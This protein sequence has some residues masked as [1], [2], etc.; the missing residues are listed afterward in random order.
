MIF[1][2]QMFDVLTNQNA[3]NKRIDLECHVINIYVCKV[4]S[5]DQSLVKKISCITN[6]NNKENIPVLVNDNNEVVNNDLDK[7]KLLNSL[8]SSQSIID[9]SNKEVPEL[10]VN[11][12]LIL[13]QITITELD[14]IDILKTLDTSKASG[15]DLISPKMLKEASEVLAYPLA[16]LFNISLLFNIF[17]Q[18]WK[19]ANVT[20]VFKKNDPIKVDN[21]RPISLLSLLGKVFEKCVRKYIHNYIVQNNLITEHQSGFTS[22][23]STTNQLLFITNEFSKALDAGKEIRVVFF[24]ISKAFDRVWHKGLLYKLSKMGIAGNLMEWIKSYLFS[25]NQRV[26]VNGTE[27]DWININAGVPQGSILG[28]LFFLVCINDIV[29]EVNCSIKLFADDTTIYIIIENSN[30]ACELLNLNLEKV[31]RW[32]ENWLVNFNPQKTE[33]LLISRKTVSAD[34][35]PLSMNNI[36]V[37]EVEKHKHLGLIFNNNLHWGDHINSM[38]TKAQ[39]KLNILRSLKFQLDR[40][41]LQIMYFSF[42]RPILEYSDIIWDNCPLYMKQSLEKINIEAAR[43]VSGATKLVSLE[44]LY[45]EVGWETLE[46]RRDKHK[47]IQFYKMI[48]GLTPSYLSD[49]IPITHNRYHQYSTRNSSDFIHP[50]CRSNFY[51]NDFIPSTVRLWNNLPHDIKNIPSLSL[52]KKTL[53]SDVEDPSYFYVGS[54]LG[55]ILHARLRM[56]CSS[57]KEHL[58][59][60]NI[61]HSPLCVCGEV[62][63]TSHYLLYCYRFDMERNLLRNALQRQLSIGVL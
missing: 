6:Q 50:A 28:P 41:S 13:D 30:T 27:S 51:Y 42:I 34:H 18:S 61:E 11:R 7:A 40:K 57:L 8:F 52:F 17:P 31:H 2:P 39:T 10:E 20:P 22:G 16:K 59:L 15:P 21:Y 4:Y 53:M 38:L 24:D 3:R 25:R 44:N 26:V 48:K 58:F 1:V 62:E 37:K 36:Q 49:L 46:K 43:I 54:R 14:V 33:S 23:D 55:Q 35:P 9:D 56:K 60:K 12:E 45:K 63:S 5:A 29:L 47:L 32:S 19:C